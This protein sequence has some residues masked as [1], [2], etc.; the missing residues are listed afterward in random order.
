MTNKMKKSKQLLSLINQAVRSSFINDRLNEAKVFNFIKT[1][2]TLPKS[3]SIFALNEFSKG[4]KR[5]L[6]KH[7]LEIE[8][9]TELTSMQVRE[10]TNA[11]KADYKI[12]EVKAVIN[13]ELLGGIKIRVGDHVFDDSVISRIEQLKEEIST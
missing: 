4:I 3:D 9:A 7:T 6:N 12:N 1:F 2:K 10:I 11:L 8:S 5:E 13:I